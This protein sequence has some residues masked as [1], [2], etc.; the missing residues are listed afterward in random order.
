M[1]RKM[2]SNDA[3]GSAHKLLIRLLAMVTGEVQPVDFI[4]QYTAAQK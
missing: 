2:G 1:G 4:Q 3:A